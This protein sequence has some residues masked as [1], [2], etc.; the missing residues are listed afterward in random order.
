MTVGTA[1][2]A[3]VAVSL[4]GIS[5]WARYEDVKYYDWIA[6]KAGRVESGCVFEDG[7][8]SFR[9]SGQGVVSCCP[10][11]SVSWKVTAGVL[12]ASP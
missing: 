5:G 4:P 6:D 2:L 7:E 11:S 1:T 8:F 3:T 12:H 10:A 9:G